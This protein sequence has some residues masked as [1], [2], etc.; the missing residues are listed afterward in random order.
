MRRRRRSTACA[1]N[2]PASR[3]NSKRSAIRPR[4]RIRPAS[5]RPRRRGVCRARQFA[6]RCA[7]QHPGQ[8]LRHGRQHGA[9]RY[10]AG[11]G[12]FRRRELSGKID[13]LAEARPAPD[14]ESL[15]N[16]LGA[17][18]AA[19][20]ANAPDAKLDDIRQDLREMRSE[21]APLGG[22]AAQIARL[23]SLR[24]PDAEPAGSLRASG[25]EP[26]GSL[27][28]IQ[29]RLGQITSRLDGI[30][31]GERIADRVNNVL[32]ERIAAL[33]G[34]VEAANGDI[35]RRADLETLVESLAARLAGGP[36][37]RGR[38]RPAH[39]RNDRGTARRRA[40]GQRQACCPACRRGARTAPVRAREPHRRNVGRQPCQRRSRRYPRPARL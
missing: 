14:L 21:I 11:A 2:S 24:E 32:G 26:A 40:A 37:Q 17:V 15:R 20:R 22:L 30:G 28:A 4:P 27:D 10:A 18:V 1:W 33:H 8:C 7:R 29:D 3:R 31:D 38:I 13:Q 25:A 23:G 5:R 9:A 39:A 19:V 35:L 16:S 12:R 34:L 36:A 6:A